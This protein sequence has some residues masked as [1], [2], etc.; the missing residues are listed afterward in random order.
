MVINRQKKGSFVSIRKGSNYWAQHARNIEAWK[1]GALCEVMPLTLEYA[2]ILA[3]DMNC[4]G[5]PFAR[6]RRS[7]CNGRIPKQE[8][9]SMDD[10]SSSTRETAMKVLEES[11]LAGVKAVLWTGG[12]EPLIWPILPD[13]IEYS[14]SLGMV[15]ALYT[16]GVMLGRNPEISKKLLS[17]SMKMMFIRVSINA[18]SPMTIRR[19]WGVK[20]PEDVYPQL[21][22]LKSL[23]KARKK[24]AEK[25][26]EVGGHVPNIQISTIIDKVNLSDLFPI[27]ETVSGILKEYTNSME[28]GDSMVVRP[29]TNHRANIYSTNDHEDYVIDEIINICGTKGQG[30]KIM[31]ESG[32][33]VY[34]G[35]GLNL[36]ESGAYQSYSELL[37]AEYQS[38]D[39]A[40]ANGLFLTVGPD[41]SV[42]L[43]TEKNCD[44]KWAFGKLTEKS[45][46]ELYNGQ[47]RKKILEMVHKY[48][49][50]PEVMEPNTRSTR[51][52]KIARAIHNGSLTDSEI[53]YIRQLSELDPPL[54]LS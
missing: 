1:N 54:L 17:P 49:L 31:N 43:C 18:I 20:D 10:V 13:M 47:E 29:I 6:S 24:V 9:A 30:N 5:C 52:D 23:L 37:R 46:Y 12:G 15:N 27:C 40:W 7:N 48:K 16:N 45:V 22:G 33:P 36:I 34:L 2:P 50:G 44:P 11:A 38:R 35:F 39:F 8:Y 26:K 41:S 25:I 19:H 32:M 28:E 51:L 14:A 53:K 21:D 42:H 4:P 3:C